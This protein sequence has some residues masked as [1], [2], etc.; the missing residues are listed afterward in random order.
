MTRGKR[1]KTINVIMKIRLTMMIKMTTIVIKMKMA[2]MMTM[3][4]NPIQRR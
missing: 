2:M 1:R 3:M 4:H